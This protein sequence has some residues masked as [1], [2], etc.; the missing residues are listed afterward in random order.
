MSLHLAIESLLLIL[1]RTFL[2]WTCRKFLIPRHA[3]ESPSI[4]EEVIP[5]STPTPT[6]DHH[7]SSPSSTKNANTNTNNIPRTIFS[8]SFSES[9]TLF[10][11]LLFQSLDIL[12]PYTRLIHWRISL[13][14]LVGLV[15]LGGPAVGAWLGFG[16]GKPIP[17]LI[18]LGLYAYVIS[19]I[20]VP[21]TSSTGVYTSIL[22]RLIVLGTVILGILSGVGVVEGL[23]SWVSSWGRPP[24]TRHEIA[25]AQRSLDRI[26][27][28]LQAAR[29]RPSTSSSSSTP[30][31]RWSK[32]SKAFTRDDDKLE[33]DGLIALESQMSSDLEDLKA[34]YDASK[35]V[36]RKIL[37]VALGVYCM[38]RVCASVLN[39]LLPPPNK[40]RNYPDILTNLIT[41]LVPS[42]S[43][44]LVGGLMRQ[45]S[46]VLVGI[47]V[48]GSL[49]VI[50]RVV[51]SRT[52]L[53]EGVEGVMLLILAQVMVRPFS[54]ALLHDA[55][56]TREQAIY[57]LSTV[58]QLRASFPPPPEKGDGE[59][60]RNLFNTI[61]PFHIFGRLFDGV[62]L[63][64][65]LLGGEGV[66]GVML[67]ILAQV[68]SIYLLSTV[69]QLRAS[70]GVLRE[71]VS[72]LGKLPE[73]CWE[74][75]EERY[76]WFDEDGEQ[77]EEQKPLIKAEKMSIRDRLVRIGQGDSPPQ[78]DSDMGRMIEPC[79]TRLDDREIGL[80]GDLLEGMLR[81]R[82]RDRVTIQEVIERPWFS[83]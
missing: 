24:P 36:L 34:R 5:L 78:N 54:F 22:A 69:V 72:T 81:Y 27:Q 15:L 18:L 44:S 58:V 19:L 47:I 11:L 41:S 45:L 71:T 56:R 26:R 57:L 74:L 20:P 70:F 2:F 39:L 9:L 16:G 51:K 21:T 48:S 7:D 38:G 59:G 25:S 40:E 80:L 77:K 75:F 17:L 49:R 12:D 55:N 35:G 52:K 30:T 32:I 73:E 10:I 53:G 65:V 29:D 82:P 33:L 68:M 3:S 43:P 23:G 62:F 4:I 42:L 6:Q 31:S 83:L 1:I 14:Y 46:L 66:E 64:V 63:G 76:T 28:D 37:R 13:S 67:L 50:R 79:G 8:L 61:P 60:E